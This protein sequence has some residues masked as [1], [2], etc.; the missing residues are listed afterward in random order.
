MGNII[1]PIISVAVLTGIRELFRLFSVQPGNQNDTNAELEQHY[2]RAREAAAEARAIM[3]EARRQVEELKQRE[4]AARM[5]EQEAS[6]MDQE[7]KQHEADAH[8]REEEAKLAAEQA[9][10]AARE[11]SQRDQASKEREKEA[12]R[13]EEEAKRLAEETKRAALEAQ[14]RGEEANARENETKRREE[15]AKIAASKAQER[16]H[17]AKKDLERANFYLSEGIH[18]QVWPTEEEFRSAKTRIQYDPEKLHFAVCGSSGSGKSSLVNAFRGLKNFDPGAAPTGVIETTTSITRN[19][20]PYNELPRSR[21]IWFD[22]PGAGTLNVPGWQYFNE[23]GLFIFDIIIL[24]YD[25]VS[26]PLSIID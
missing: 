2:Q 5:R 15:E 1:T 13:R 14:I 6:Q 19:P 16:E 17:Q 12:Q 10:T 7:A 3:Q 18:P 21:F 8:R 4:E 9:R 11:A 26:I 23:Q 22:V 25:A 20:D 24:V